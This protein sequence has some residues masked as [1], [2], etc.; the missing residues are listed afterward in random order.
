M[1]WLKRRRE[2]RI[3][4][5]A[6]KTRGD[7]LIK[8]VQNNDFVGAEMHAKG[9][10]QMDLGDAYCWGIGMG[11]LKA[12]EQAGAYTP[13]HR[14]NLVLS[15]NGEQVS[16]EKIIQDTAGEA[17]GALAASQMLVTLANDDPDMWLAIWKAADETLKVEIVVYMTM[18]AV[19]P[20]EGVEL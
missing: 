2:E 12:M 14:V 13:G 1:G 18:M 10:V 5:Y 6:F 3:R 11:I 20:P 8:N 15:E 7:Y 19:A 4:E 16:P 17:R 9:L